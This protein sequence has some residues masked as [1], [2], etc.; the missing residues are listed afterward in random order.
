MA[1]SRRPEAGWHGFWGRGGIGVGLLRPLGALWA[2]RARR[3]HV[4]HR[5]G[6]DAPFEAPVP[7]IVVGNLSV[8]GSGKTPFVMALVEWLRGQGWKPGIVSRGYIRGRFRKGVP[9]LVGAEASA[10]E[11]GDEAV[12][13]ARRTGVPMAVGRD[14]PAAVRCL[15]EQDVDIVVSDD[16]LQHYALARDLEVVMVDGGRGL[17]NGRCLPAGPLREP[18]ERLASVDLVVATAPVT[19]AVAAL[20]GWS[21]HLVPAGL[22]PGT[23]SASGHGIAADGRVPLTELPAGPVHAVAGIGNP[24]RF[25]RTLEALDLEVVRHPFPDHHV[26]MREELEL[27]GNGP[28]LM[29]E[30][31]LLRCQAVWANWP[32]ALRRRCTALCVTAEVDAGVFAAIARRLPERGAA[33]GSDENP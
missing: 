26:F 31:D 28:I 10:A 21:M 1:E 3:R 27:P 16:G 12:L 25:F 32:A 13:L 6:R 8:G 19:A 23:A 17:G 33:A 18:P 20:T 15:L 4:R 24:E 11:V 5:A 9:H 7:V 2:M 30:K 29:T 22:L 14:R